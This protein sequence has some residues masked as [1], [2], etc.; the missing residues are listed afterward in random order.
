[1]SSVTFD[2]FDNNEDSNASKQKPL[3]TVDLKDDKKVLEWMKKDYDTKE[4][5][6]RT[7]N[8]TYRENLCLFKGIH[9]KSQDSRDLQFENG[10][11]VDRNPKIVI[12]HIYDL[13]QTTVSKM[14]RF[15]P[16]IVVS[17]A[18]QDEWADGQN[19]RTIKSLIDSRWYEVEIDSI[20]TQ[21]ELVTDIFGDAYGMVE[22]DKQEGGID[23][24]F[25][26]VAK[27]G[28]T[29]IEMDDGS[30]KKVNPR[31]ARGDVGYTIRTP[32]R[33][34]PQHKKQWKDV[35]HVTLIDY[36]DVEELKA[37]YPD[38]AADIKVNG[39]AAYDIV[40]ME[41][42]DTSTQVLVMTLIH[43]PSEF[44]PEGRWII[45]THDVTLS[46]EKYKYD[47]GRMPFFRQSDIDVP[48]ELHGRSSISLIR[49][50]QMHF[51]NLASGIARNHGLASAPKW[52]V[53]KGAV[54]ISS[55]GN[56]S[57]VVQF[58]GPVGPQLV[59]YSP[60]SP[61]IFGYM[62][63][64][65]V[66]MEKLKGIHAVSRG[67]PPTGV[68][69]A[70]GM[71]FLDEQENER[72]TAR[73]A[74]RNRCITE[75]AQLTA[76]LM[77]QHYKES[78]ERFI[79]VTGENHEISM[80]AYKGADF[81]K[82]YDIRIQKG[83]FLPETKGMRYKAIVEMSTA[84]PAIF[85]PEVV[86]SLL[87]LALDQKFKDMASVS[88]KAAEYENSML[89]KG[90]MIA[91][92]GS[93]EDHLTHYKL[94]LID[95]QRE[96]FKL[97]PKEIQKA[98]QEHISTTEYLIWD[99]AQRNP[100]FAQLLSTQFPLFP[101]FFD[102]GDVA[103]VN[104]MQNSPLAQKA[105]A[106]GQAPLPTEPPVEQGAQGDAPDLPENSFNPTEGEIADGRTGQ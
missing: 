101:V 79:K 49:Q 24:A 31:R 98:K 70:V 47:H 88:V 22:W 35:Q 29:E 18:N 11:R 41:D 93:Y 62:D 8:R 4:R 19:A 55:L 59:S 81:S 37:A 66:Y 46:N 45:C 82:P 57:T 27:T 53:P 72:A 9:Y 14:T 86:V 10:R 26:R 13:V 51:N 100:L 102:P 5:R 58:K 90:K 78:D 73:I 32:D 56:D 23:P 74:R 36:W 99:K 50:P 20:Y 92:P 16:N 69:S 61:E 34:W 42:F 84:F 63:K 2:D 94:H 6:A 95:M 33:V 67:T 1:M 38:H 96:S 85:P 12:N 87:D 3:W 25:E 48:G 64:L 39:H 76:S 15:R 7:R 30:K 40:T 21:L 83:S 17:P 60:T 43:P 89:S 104:P 71:E 91:E 75:C 28:T 65:E 80:E 106:Q 44:L 54:E 103:P 77:G 52:V 68:T 105:M 97:L